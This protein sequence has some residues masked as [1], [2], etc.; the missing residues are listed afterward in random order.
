MQMPMR[1]PPDSRSIMHIPQVENRRSMTT[2][3]LMLQALRPASPRK[4][5]A[6]LQAQP[7]GRSPSSGG[8]PRAQ[9]HPSSQPGSTTAAGAGVDQAAG[10]PSQPCSPALQDLPM[11]VFGGSP[12]GALGQQVGQHM[13]QQVIKAP[14][15]AHRPV[16][17]PVVGP[18]IC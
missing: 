17:G 7:A 1:A 10:P 12:R 2:N 13:G 16:G 18:E 9:Q 14:G 15:A 11:P 4:V 5:L 6:A 8:A 3:Q